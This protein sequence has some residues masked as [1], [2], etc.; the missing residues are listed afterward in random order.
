M[1]PRLC[2][3]SP[4]GDDD[5][6]TPRVLEESSS[7]SEVLQASEDRGCAAGPVSSSLSSSSSLLVLLVPL[8]SSS[9]SYRAPK[10]HA[11]AQ[12][13]ADMTKRNENKAVK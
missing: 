10:D 7:Q 3:P 8:E 4:I 1:G 11:L 13:S 9:D 12:E 5:G 6:S 2:E